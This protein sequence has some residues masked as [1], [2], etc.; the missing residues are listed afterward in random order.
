MITLL[1][2]ARLA[3]SAIDVDASY[4]WPND[5]VCLTVMPG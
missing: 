3:V 1:V 5:N 2:P 4:H